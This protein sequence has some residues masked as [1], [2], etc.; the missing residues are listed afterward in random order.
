MKTLIVSPDTRSLQ[1]RQVPDSALLTGG[2]PLFLREEG[3]E[4]SLCV[5]PA[6]RIGRL[7]LG[8][9]ERFASRYYDAATLVALNIGSGGP[10]VM[11]DADLIADNALVVGSWLPVPEGPVAVRGDGGRV[12]AEWTGLRDAFD[13]AVSAVS[14]RSTLKTGDIIA[15]TEPCLPGVYGPRQRAEWTLGGATALSFK[16]I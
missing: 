5:M 1:L 3:T 8:V 4:V 6:V 2:R 15:L 13:R 9:S 16:I 11:T 12:S 7:G 10:A 14:S